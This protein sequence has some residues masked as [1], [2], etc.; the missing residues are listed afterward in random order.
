LLTLSL[1]FSTKIRVKKTLTV[2]LVLWSVCAFAQFSQGTFFV[3]A[4]TEFGFGRFKSSIKGSSDSFQSSANRIGV[5]GDIQYGITDK[6]SSGLNLRFGSFSVSDDEIESSSPFITLGLEGRYYFIANDLGA[7]VG[8][9]F[10][11]A[12]MES[13][14]STEDFSGIFLGLHSGI[15]YSFPR[16]LLGARGGFGTFST[17]GEEEVLDATFKVKSNLTTIN[18]AVYGTRF[19]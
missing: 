15:E 10:G 16:I 1:N 17:S 19:F 12:F 7:Y 4:G 6:I 9:E 13:N 18:L 2:L 8:P 14:T 11:L 3:S 5:R